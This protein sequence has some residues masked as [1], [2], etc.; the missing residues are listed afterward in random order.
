VVKFLEGMETK[1]NFPVIIDKNRQVA[2][3]FSA[4]VLPTTLIID[5][6]GKI[7]YYHVGYKKGDEKSIRNVV[8]QAVREI[9]R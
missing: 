8:A 2:Q 7:R 6:H 3:S 9:K 1:I 5:A 4:M